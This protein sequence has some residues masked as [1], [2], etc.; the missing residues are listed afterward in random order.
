MR[1]CGDYVAPAVDNRATDRSSL[2]RASCSIGWLSLQGKP[3]LVTARQMV[4]L[5]ACTAAL[6]LFATRQ[7]FEFPVQFLDLPAHVIRVLNNVCG[8]SL[9]G[10]IRDHS[11]NVAVGGNQLE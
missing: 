7:L 4:P 1:E 9:I 6:A 8:Q 2:G 5:R 11:V 3:G 10:A